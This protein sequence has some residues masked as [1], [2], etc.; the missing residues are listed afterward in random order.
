MKIRLVVAEL[1]HADRGTDTKTDIMKRIV[2]LRNF[3][4]SPTNEKANSSVPNNICFITNPACFSHKLT[5]VMDT[6]MTWH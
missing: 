1:F 4:N 2:A 6:C 5:V 3:A